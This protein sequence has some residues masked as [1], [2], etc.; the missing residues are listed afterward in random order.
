MPANGW[1]F[2]SLLIPLSDQQAILVTIGY[3]AAGASLCSHILNK[4]VLRSWTCCTRAGNI[5]TPSVARCG[6]WQAC[7]IL[8]A[9]LSLQR[10]G[11]DLWKIPPLRHSGA[12]KAEIKDRHQATAWNWHWKKGLHVTFG[13]RSLRGCGESFKEAL[14]NIQEGLIQLYSKCVSADSCNSVG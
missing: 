10:G 11:S 3:H 6:T 8:S 9:F 12:M 1:A 7:S 4:G 13:W 2:C 14:R 5:N